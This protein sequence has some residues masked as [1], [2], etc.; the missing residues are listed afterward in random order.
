MTGEDARGTDRPVVETV[1]QWLR[2]GGRLALFTVLRTWGS[3]P[4][5]PGSLLA[6]REDGRLVGSVSGGCVEDDLR[7]RMLDGRL[8]GTQPHTRRYGEDGE[9]AARFGLPCGGTLELLVEPLAPGQEHGLETVSAAMEAGRC[10]R[11][12]VRMAS[13]AVEVD[14]EPRADPAL[15]LEAETVG[16]LFGP[17]WRL[18]IIGAGQ[19]GG[20]LA[21]MAGRLDYGVTVCEP[22]REYAERWQQAGSGIFLDT[23]MPDDAVAA[24]RPDARSAVVATTHDPK[25]DD[26][27]LLEALSTSAFYVGALGSKRN[28]DRRRERLAGLGLDR[29]AVDRLR[30]PMGLPIGSRTPPEIAVSVMAEVTAIR[31]DRDHRAAAPPTASGAG[32]PVP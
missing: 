22:R 3:S 4:R 13:G 8:P 2:E 18:M 15:A 19:L 1:L 10:A 11:R 23:R 5:P 30:G 16:K 32:Y 20:Q 7:T 17:R 21:D 29:S 31:N 27:A 14:P 24:W 25:L 12:T 28:N 9:E 6:I 26:L